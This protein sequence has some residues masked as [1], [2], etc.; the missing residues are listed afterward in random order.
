MRSSKKQWRLLTLVSLVMAANAAAQSTPDPQ[1]HEPFNYFALH[2]GKHDVQ[3]WPALV[4]LGNG[5]EFDGQVLLDDKLA[6]GLQVGREYEKYRYD[7]EYQR[8]AYKASNI[9]LNALSQ[10]VSGSG[11]YQALTLNAYRMKDFSERTNGYIGAGIGYGAAQ[12][13]QMGFSAG[14]QCFPEADSSGF[15]WQARI[16]IERLIGE[17]SRLGLQYSRIFDMP[18]PSSGRAAPSVQYP[19]KDIDYL[20][21]VY[22]RDF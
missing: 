10:A 7:I 4:S 18:G 22:R 21:I 3:A 12:L 15:V 11:H 13:P 17:H 1:E 16:G 8:G 2:L 19:D 9:S 5:I 20:S 14:C 6:F